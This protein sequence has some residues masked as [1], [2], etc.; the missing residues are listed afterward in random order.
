MLG[1]VTAALTGVNPSTADATDNDATIRKDLGFAE[2]LGW[3]RIIKANKFTLRSKDVR[4]LARCERP[5]HADADD[6]LRAIFSEAD[7]LVPCWGPLSKLPQHLR[8]RWREVV[9]LMEASGK[10]IMCLGTALD[11]QPRHTLMLPYTTP[12]TPWTLAA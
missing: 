9:A 12:L 1:G 3:S 2:R 8:G 6:Y 5:N 10:P 11:G 4:E 7:V